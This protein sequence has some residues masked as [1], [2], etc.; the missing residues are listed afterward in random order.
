MLNRMRSGIPLCSQFWCAEAILL[1]CSKSP[2]GT[3]GPRKHSTD[4]D[5]FIKQLHSQRSTT[6]VMRLFLFLLLFVSA[7]S[8]GILGPLNKTKVEE[9][10]EDRIRSEV[11]HVKELLSGLSK[12]KGETRSRSIEKGDKGLKT[13]RTCKQSKTGGSEDCREGTPSLLELLLA[14]REFP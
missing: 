12:D 3:K 8:T 10:R 9:T 1:S 6:G 7:S 4:K 2:S 13:K 11:S 14:F 5:Y